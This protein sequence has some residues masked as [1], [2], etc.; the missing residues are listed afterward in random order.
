MHFFTDG[1][2]LPWDIPEAYCA[3]CKLPVSKHRRGGECV[4]VQPL[5][6]EAERSAYIRE[7][8]IS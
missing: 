3:V 8:Q 1:C 2:E 6:S 4:Q 5:S 7:D